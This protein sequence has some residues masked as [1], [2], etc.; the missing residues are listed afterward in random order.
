MIVSRISLRDLINYLNRYP[1]SISLLMKI[2]TLYFDSFHG[3]LSYALKVKEPK[4]N[5][6]DKA[7]AITIEWNLTMSKVDLLSYPR[8]QVEVEPKP[9][10]QEDPSLQTFS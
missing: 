8:V 3:H 9:C 1:K 2:Q 6:Q 5:E 10:T 7:Y 4:T